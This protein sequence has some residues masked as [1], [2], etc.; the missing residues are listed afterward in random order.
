VVVLQ[1]VLEAHGLL[2]GLAGVGVDGGQL[3]PAALH[4]ALLLFHHAC[5]VGW[6]ALA[7]ADVAFK[8][9][10]GVVASTAAGA[11]AQQSHI[12]KFTATADRAMAVTLIGYTTC[13]MGSIAG[14]TVPHACIHACMWYCRSQR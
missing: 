7:A 2:A 6:I 1:P 5:V 9:G 11:A 3:L 14:P 13:C 10:V 4:G 12:R 8:H